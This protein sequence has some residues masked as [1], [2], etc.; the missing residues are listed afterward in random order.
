MVIS[1]LE[2]MKYERVE[3]NTIVLTAAIDSLAREGGG[4][5][6]GTYFNIYCHV[7]FF[8]YLFYYLISVST[9]FCRNVL[10]SSETASHLLFISSS[11]FISMY[12]SIY[13]FRPSL[14]SLCKCTYVYI[15]HKYK[16]MYVYISLSLSLSLTSF[17]SLFLSLARDIFSSFYHQ[18]GLISSLSH[19]L[20]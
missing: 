9:D 11:L 16:C 1:L 10:C 17:L 5:Y 15:I 13:I 14:L 12:L 7:F 3:P 4:V 19:F 8:C 2:R 18:S 20:M 6:T